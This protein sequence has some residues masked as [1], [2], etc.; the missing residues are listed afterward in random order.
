MLIDLKIKMER[1]MEVSFSDGQC[2]VM[3][4]AGEWELINEE[5]QEIE[6]VKPEED[7]TTEE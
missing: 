5:N 4:F 3:N 6:I 7:N 2:F 1:K